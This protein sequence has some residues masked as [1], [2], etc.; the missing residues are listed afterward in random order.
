MPAVHVAVSDLIFSSRIAAEA[1]ALNVQ[2]Q[3]VRTPAACTDWQQSPPRLLIIDLNLTA[4]DPLDLIGRAKT[5]STPPKIIAFLSHVQQE[6]ARQAAD[7]GA[8]MVMPRSTF[9][10]ELPNLLRGIK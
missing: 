9:A 6:L 4:T 1:R 10:V 8:D 5:L 2:V 7:K 3:W